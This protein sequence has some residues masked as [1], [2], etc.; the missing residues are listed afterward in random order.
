MK[1]AYIKIDR[2]NYFLII[3]CAFYVDIRHHTYTLS[4]F[5]Y[6]HICTVDFISIPRDLYFAEEHTKHSKQGCYTNYIRYNSPFVI[7]STA[8]AIN[9]FV[10]WIEEN[11]NIIYEPSHLTFSYIVFYSTICCIVFSFRSFIS[12]TVSN[13]LMLLKLIA[14][15]DML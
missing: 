4:V 5:I 12:D 15:V 10:I 11:E 13:G 2:F 6:I 7:N 8:S 1:I 14:N 3:S 9:V